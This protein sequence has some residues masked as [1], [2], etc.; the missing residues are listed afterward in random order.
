[1]QQPRFNLGLLG[2]SKAQRQWVENYLAPQ[3][4]PP[5]QRGHADG[6]ELSEPLWQ[7]ADFQEA[8]ALLINTQHARLDG[9]QMVRFGADASEPDAGVLGVN[10]ADLSIP[11]ALTGK[12]T[13]AIASAVADNTPQVTLQDDASLL[14]ALQ[15]CAAS[16][17]T[18]RTLYALALHLLERREELDE[19]HTYHLS[20]SGVLDAI[21]D[22]PGQRVM[23][24]PGLRPFELAD[25][26]WEPRPASANSLPPG[27]AVWLMEELAWVYALHRTH[28]ALPERYLREPI[29]LR[30]TPRVRAAMFY[31]RHLQL[32]ELLGQQPCDYDRLHQ[33]FPFR[34]AQLKRDLYALYLC[35]AITTNLRRARPV[36]DQPLSSRPNSSVDPGPS[37]PFVLDTVRTPLH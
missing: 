15:Y 11:Y 14:K 12:I 30:R 32:L 3:P 20:R 7:I 18:L 27:F 33:A 34:T 13:P 35:R 5:S 8:N 21:V 1:M 28:V 2:F 26:V 23:V 4:A 9:Q 36:A 10:P 17:R 37:V 25:A 31:P 29:Y 22:V 6:A 19:G 24:R 16:L